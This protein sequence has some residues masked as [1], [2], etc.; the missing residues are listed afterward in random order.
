MNHSSHVNT[1]PS[2]APPPTPPLHQQQNGS[3]QHQHVNNNNN[4]NQNQNINSNQN[5]NSDNITR[6]KQFLLTLLKLAQNSLP[7]KYPIVRSLIQDLVVNYYYRFP[8]L[9]GH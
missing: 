9:T 5:T 3:A 7:E 1:T 6:L 2:P 4:N 8:L